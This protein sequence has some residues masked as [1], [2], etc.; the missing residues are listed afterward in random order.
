MRTRTVRP[1]VRPLSGQGGNCCLIIN[2]I[3]ITRAHA[4]YISIR[5]QIFQTDFFACSPR[6]PVSIS[7]RYRKTVYYSEA[8]NILRYRT[9]SR[10]G[11]T[12]ARVDTE[13][14]RKL[15]SLNG[16]FSQDIPCFSQDNPPNNRCSVHEVA[17]TRVDEVCGDNRAGEEES[18]RTCVSRR[19]TTCV[20]ACVCARAFTTAIIPE[21]ELL[22]PA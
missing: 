20:C 22:R 16:C 19:R 9:I 8:R 2:E 10:T 1:S 14:S 4:S 11:F 5:R 13:R 7:Y 12:L 15:L 18:H 17:R 6:L 3:I 21:P